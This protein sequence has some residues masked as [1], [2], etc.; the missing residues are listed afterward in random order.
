MNH[1]VAVR[2]RGKR[3]GKCT[4][5]GRGTES[6]WNHPMPGFRSASTSSAY[7]PYPPEYYKIFRDMLLLVN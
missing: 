6:V 4:E 3:I 1:H 5:Y 7:V 2:S